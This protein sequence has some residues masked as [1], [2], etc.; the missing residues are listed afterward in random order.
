[1]REARKIPIDQAPHPATFISGFYGILTTEE[2]ER[3]LM[4]LT[5]F[6]VPRGGLIYSPDEGIDSIYILAQGQ[7]KIIQ[8]RE[9]PQVMQLLK[10]GDIFG[11]VPYFTHNK[12]ETRHRASRTASCVPIR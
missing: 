9:H 5:Y 6:D 12:Y 4:G 7:A 3:F 1:M 2:R 10:T 11:F 8:D